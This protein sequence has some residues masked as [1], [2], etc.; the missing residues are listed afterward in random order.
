MNGCPHPVRY[1]SEGVTREAPTERVDS[2]GSRSDEAPIRLGPADW[3]RTGGRG[4]RGGE[5]QSCATA[6]SSP[7]GSWA[8]RTATAW[9]SRP[10]LGLM[11][12]DQSQIRSLQPGGAAGGG[13]QGY[14]PQIVDL[15]RQMIG[16]AK[17]MGMITTLQS[18]PQ[19]KAVLA[20][21]E[22]MHLVVSGKLGALQSNPLFK[23]LMSSPGLHVLR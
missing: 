19:V 8:S 17:M 21:P 5:P 6:A 13:P 3:H 9:S 10:A 4:C 14:G 18:D 2:I 15:Q 7:A 20:D 22:F 23:A 11:T 16:N 1:L 12:I